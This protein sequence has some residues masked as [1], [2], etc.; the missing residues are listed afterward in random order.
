MLR[1]HFEKLMH[2]SIPS[3]TIPPGDPGDSHILV[4]PE[5]RFSLVCGGQNKN[6]IILRKGAIFASSLKQISSSSFHMFIYAR[7]EQC[8]LTGGPIYLLII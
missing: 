3:L 2:Q 8:D 6:S 7:S 5:V 1:V 4:V